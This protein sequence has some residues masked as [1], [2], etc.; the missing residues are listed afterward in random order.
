M[1]WIFCK[2]F[3]KQARQQFEG[4]KVWQQT[5]RRKPG[6]APVLQQFAGEALF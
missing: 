2:G 5:S 1:G 6:I 4:C 3:P